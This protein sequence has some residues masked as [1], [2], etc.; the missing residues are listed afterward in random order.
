[1]VLN[2]LS[3]CV[4]VYCV[5]GYSGYFS[6]GS[7]V[8]GD[9]LQ[10]Y[11]ETPSVAVV[12]MVLALALAWSYPLQCH[13]CR[14]CLAS[15]IWDTTPEKLG[16][17]KFYILTYSIALGSFGI[18]MVVK[19]LSVVLELVGSIGSPII[20]FI[21]P[22]LFYYK[23]TDPKIRLQPGYEIK[24]KIAFAYVIFGS[25]II[26]FALSMQIV[27]LVQ[28]EDDDSGCGKELCK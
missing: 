7:S 28:G 2:S 15:L 27:G 26:P 24:R 8:C 9:I 5:V 23:M 6:Y 21:L 3:L 25:L 20:S 4:I 17:K 1:M 18:S 10:S 16:S 11:P 12:R 19:N 22:G 13:P 14:K